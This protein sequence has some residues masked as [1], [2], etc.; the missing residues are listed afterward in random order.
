MAIITKPGSKSA[1]WGVVPLAG[2]TYENARITKMEITDEGTIEPLPDS[3]GETTGLVGYDNKQGVDIEIILD[4]AITP[5][6]FMAD[7]V[8]LG[9]TVNVETAKRMWEYKGWQ[10]LSVQGKVYPNL[11][12]DSSSANL[13][14][15]RAP[16]RSPLA[17]WK[18]C[19]AKAA[20]PA[21][22]KK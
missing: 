20:A 5:P 10:K 7:I 15:A 19:E 14:S 2:D 8:V 18:P 6:A 12:A 17:R 9:L 21:T 4:A 1:Y 16:R 3:F 22:E 13:E 11:E